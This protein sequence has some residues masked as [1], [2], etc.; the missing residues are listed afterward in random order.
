MVTATGSPTA[1]QTHVCKVDWRTQINDPT[2]TGKLCAY[3]K[4]L[5]TC[6]TVKNAAGN[7]DVP[8]Y[9][10]KIATTDLV[11]TYS[12][13]AEIASNYDR[14]KAKSLCA[15]TGTETVLGKVVK[16]SYACDPMFDAYFKTQTACNWDKG[17]DTCTT[18]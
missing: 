7:A 16:V 14:C 9:C 15:T 3:N 1:T 5:D 4:G 13:S 2:I 8:A 12:Q 17:V 11:A 18:G 6:T 10:V